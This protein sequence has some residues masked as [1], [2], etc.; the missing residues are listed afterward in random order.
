MTATTEAILTIDEGTTGTRAAWVT[1]DGRT[2]GIEYRPLEVS[3]PAPGVVEQDADEIIEKT[4]DAC[5]AVVAAARDAGVTLRALAIATQ[6][7]TSVLWDTSTGRALVP[8]MVWQDSRHAD[9]LASLAPAWDERLIASVGRPVGVRSPYLWAAHHLRGTPAV[10]DAYRAGR[11]GFGTIDTWLVWHLSQERTMLST[12]TNA[13]SSGAYRLAGHDYRRDWIEALGF[14]TELLPPL[15]DDAGPMGTTDAEAIGVSIPIR[16]AAGDQHAGTVG[17]GCLDRGRAMCVHGTGS[18]VDLVVGTSEPSHPG[19]YEG[20]L[21]LTAW[22]A[23]GA[24][25]FAVETFTA[26]TGSALNWLCDTLGLFESPRQI[27]ELAARATDAGSV[28]FVPALTGVRMPVVEPRVRAG[29]TGLGMEV[30]K[31]QIALAVLQGIAHSVAS[32]AEAD[33]ETAGVPIAEIAVGGGL[34]ASA[35]LLQAQADLI[36]VPMRRV[37]EP[38]MASL[39][40]AAFLAGAGEHLWADL[41]SAAATLRTEAVFEPA[42]PA[43]R[44]DAARAEWHDRIG[45]EIAF[46]RD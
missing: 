32:S 6:R 37:H 33:A 43:D 28:H 1:A 13:T 44:R 8:A 9:E 30:T 45:R 39:R 42:W 4:L 16:A 41:P 38:E 18:F 19:R 10:R 3:A 26:T 21:T 36:G 35:P 5:R 25:V 14:P 46:A 2:H 17:L 34:S 11:L 31:E 40:G 7:A 27:S 15:H 22:R 12:A 24:S 29:L 20:A 23:G